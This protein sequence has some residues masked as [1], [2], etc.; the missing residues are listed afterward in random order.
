[1]KI[2][3]AIWLLLG[4][5]AGLL[6]AGPAVEEAEIRFQIVNAGLTVEGTLTGLEADVQFDPAHP[7]L[8]TIRAAVPVSSIRTGIGFR[9]QHL[10]KPDYFDAEKHPAILLQSTA[11]RPTGRNQY[12]GQFRLTIKGIQHDVTMPFTVS[13]TN[14]LRG[15]L[16]LRRLDFNLGRPSSIL[17]DDVAVSIRVRLAK[18]S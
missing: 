15:Q 6:P 3:L 12:E 14:E 1:M 5:G 17:A 10:Q 13:A 7:E 8:A 2:L 11:I 4:L 9:D 16:R 18:G